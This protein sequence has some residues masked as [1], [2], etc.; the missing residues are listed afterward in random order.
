MLNECETIIMRWCLFCVQFECL[1]QR[2]S[3]IYAAVLW[4]VASFGEMSRNWF[5]I[6]VA[7]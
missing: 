6:N 1:W 5:C 2:D 3:V 7:V 4:R